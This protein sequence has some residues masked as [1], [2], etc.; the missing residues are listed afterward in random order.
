VVLDQMGAM[1]RLAQL[2]AASIE[3]APSVANLS[4]D[5][6]EQ[7]IDGA[8]A[9]IVEQRMR[10]VLSYDNDARDDRDDEAEDAGEEGEQLDEGNDSDT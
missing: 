1:V 9:R 2:S 7:E 4:D 6:L 10:G 8:V 3:G 5:E